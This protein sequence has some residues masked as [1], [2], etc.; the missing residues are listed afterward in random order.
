MDGASPDHLKTV[1]ATSSKWRCDALMAINQKRPIC[2]ES[3][4]AAFTTK[5]TSTIC[6]QIGTELCARS[7]ETQEDLAVGDDVQKPGIAWSAITSLWPRPTIVA[8]K[9]KEPTH[10][11]G[12]GKGSE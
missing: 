8:Q 12:T 5:C 3:L 2:S 10:G 4:L 1:S 7:A 6:L 9:S 11:N